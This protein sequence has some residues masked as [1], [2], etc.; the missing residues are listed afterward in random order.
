MEEGEKEAKSN[1]PSQKE[2]EQT[3]Q[4]TSIER[5]A[6]TSKPSADEVPEVKEKGMP[7]VENRSIPSLEDEILKRDYEA[8]SF[9]KAW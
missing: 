9:K 7:K 8:P 3:P 5:K 6:E 1:N 4:S 2:K